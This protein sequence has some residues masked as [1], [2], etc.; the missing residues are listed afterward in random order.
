MEGPLWMIQCKREKQLGPKRVQAIIADAVAAK[1][2]PYGYVL[3]APANFSKASYDTFREE[4]RQRGVS[5]FYLWGRAELE[6]M[7]L[8]PKNDHILFAFFGISLVSR[9]R[10]RATE[11]RATIGAKNKLLKLLGEH[12]T[13]ASVLLRDSNDSEYPYESQYKDFESHPRWREYPVVQMHPL[14]L[15]CQVRKFYAFADRERKEWDFTEVVDLTNRES[16]S[17]EKRQGRHDV[18]QNVEAAW[19]ALPFSN[20]AHF[21]VNRLLRFRDIVVIDGEGD[22]AYKMPHIFVP[23]DAHRGPFHGGFEYLEVGQQEIDLDDFKR[24]SKFP[25][26][27]SAPVFGTIHRDK[28]LRPGA[29]LRMYLTKYSGQPVLYDCDGTYNYLRPGD[30]ISVE[31]APGEK[32]EPKYVKV[33]HRRTERREEFLKRYHDDPN[34]LISVEDQ[35]GR[36][37]K[38]QESIEILELKAVYKWQFERAASQT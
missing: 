27:F 37:V 21:I 19:E 8:L 24:V 5:E 1:A 7:L 17:H 35:I 33:T 20:Q 29:T 11:I 31:Q 25:K 13:H 26:T 14:G 32:G 6:D 15:I 38:A 10:S 3:V 34:A 30:V 2:P 16:E 36:A 18:Q 4:L 22:A 9:R 28:V 23:F 12:P